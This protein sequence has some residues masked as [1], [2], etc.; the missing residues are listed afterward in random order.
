MQFP[1]HLA[2]G[3]LFHR[4]QFPVKK[5]KSVLR[6]PRELQ[7]WQHSFCSAREQASSLRA[8]HLAGGFLFHRTQ[9]PVK[10][11]SQIQNLN[12]TLFFLYFSFIYIYIYI[13]CKMTPAPSDGEKQICI[14][15][16][17]QSPI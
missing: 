9:F 3:F 4:T 15:S 12:L 17:S 1:V 13:R 10:Q 7:L 14:S 2:G 8:A 16:G 5:N 6:T 11:K